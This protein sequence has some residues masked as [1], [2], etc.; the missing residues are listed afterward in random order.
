MEAETVANIII[1]GG[2]KLE[3]ALRKKMLE[4]VIHWSLNQQACLFLYFEN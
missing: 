1:G 3:A 2:S 4:E